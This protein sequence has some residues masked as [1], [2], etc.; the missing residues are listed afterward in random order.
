MEKVKISVIL[1]CYNE[2]NYIDRCLETIFG[3]S[4]VEGGYEVIVVDGLSKDGTRDILMGWKQ[5][6]NELVIIDNPARI[7]PVAMNLGIKAATGQYIIFLSAHVE[8]SKDLLTACMSTFDT[9]D[10]DN[11]G[12]VLITLPGKDSLQGKIVQ[13]ITTHRFG[14]GNSEFRVGL[15]D[16]YVDTVV[17]GCYKRNVFNRIGLH[18]ERLVR[19]Q[20]YEI[21]RRLTKTGGKIWQDPTIKSYYYN[22][23]T[24]RGLLHQAWSN[25]KW[26][27][28]MW[29]LAPYS[30]APRHS[31]PGIFA[32]SLVLSLV[33]AVLFSWGWVLPVMI[34]IPYLI[35]ALISAYQQS[36]KYSWH[37]FPFLPFLFFGYHFLYGSGTLWGCLCLLIGRAPVQK[38]IEP[39]PGAGCKRALNIQGGRN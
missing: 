17:Y 33:M 3:F 21:N 4:S 30:F 10:A 34:L 32:L 16:G 14:V 5:R 18:D 7:T 38:D 31:I 2:V 12:G 24:V 11:I 1:L 39:W 9:V 6:K 19:N 15:K 28:W 36:R 23:S 13:A 20:D 27:P 37:L 8:Y 29:Y 26:N 35:L 25:G 22:Q